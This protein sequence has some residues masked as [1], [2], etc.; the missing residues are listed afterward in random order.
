MKINLLTLSLIIT[1]LIFPS[2]YAQNEKSKGTN[3]VQATKGSV[4]DVSLCYLKKISLPN[5]SVVNVIGK[6]YG[7]PAYNGLEVYIALEPSNMVSDIQKVVL[8]DNIAGIKD[9]KVNNNIINATVYEEGYSSKSAY[10]PSVT[11]KKIILEVINAEKG[12]FKI[13]TKLIK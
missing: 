9:I 7:D 5:Y 8:A 12:K 13:S 11:T 3:E 10:E 4:E 2:L 6:C 1:I